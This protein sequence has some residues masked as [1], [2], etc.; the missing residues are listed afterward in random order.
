MQG[1]WVQFLTFASASW[2]GWNAV[3]LGS[4]RGG[5]LRILMYQIL[6]P[7]GLKEPRFATFQTPSSYP[8]NQEFWVQEQSS[9]I[10]SNITIELPPLDSF[11]SHLRDLQAAPEFGFISQILQT[12]HSI[13]HTRKRS[14]KYWFYKEWLN[15]CHQRKNMK[16]WH[17][18]EF[19]CPPMLFPNI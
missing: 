10:T 17:V 1:H 16:C 13:H 4:W 12:I 9:D 3:G 8:T 6:M 15:I 11:K 5:E 18:W 14:W 19:I 7:S 2:P